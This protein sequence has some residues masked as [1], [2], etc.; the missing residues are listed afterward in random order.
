[1]ESS[2]QFLIGLTPA[3]D[4]GSAYRTKNANGNE[5]QRSNML[6]R[7]SELVVQGDLV[8]VVHGRY[9]P[10]SVSAATLLVVE[11]HFLSYKSDR[12]F[13]QAVITLQLSSSD[14][15]KEGPV[16]ASI[17]PY[18]RF[19][20]NPTVTSE[21]KTISTNIGAN[22]GVGGVGG[23]N[24]GLG[25]SLSKVKERKHQTTLVGSTRLELR[26]Y[27]GKDTARWVL[28]ENRSQSDGIPSFFRAGIL[29]KRNSDAE[30]LATIQITAEADLAYSIRNTFETWT[31]KTPVDDPILFDPS[32]EPQGEYPLP[33]IDLDH[34]SKYNLESIMSVEALGAQQS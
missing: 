20:L 23:A 33:E 15:S 13:R 31:G 6:D 7:G 26:N 21:E 2:T 22:V 32:L 10:G 11:F 18:G 34:L 24:V 28:S 25:W 27:G 1:M 29:L 8:R 5:R 30:F 17:T 3:G 9:G 16:V 12:R 14:N 19:C 4:E